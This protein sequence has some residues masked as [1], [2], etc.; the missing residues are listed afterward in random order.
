LKFAQALPE[1]AILC[2]EL[3]NYRMRITASLVE[4]FNAREGAH[5]DLVLALACWHGEYRSRRLWAL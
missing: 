2:R 1:T 5:D 4:T 3:E